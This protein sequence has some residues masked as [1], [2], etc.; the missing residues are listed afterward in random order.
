MK[1]SQLLTDVREM[2]NIR[3]STFK[4]WLKAAKPIADVEV[5]DIDRMTV[6]RYW[7]SQLKPIGTLS[8]E[9][10]RRR[11]S[12]LTGI[13]NMATEDEIIDAPN[14][15][16]K[17]SRKIK[18][19]TDYS[20][21]GKEY[22]V[23]PFSA[24]GRYQTD[25]IFLAIWF[26]GFRIG[27]IAGLMPNEIRF[28]NQVPYFRIRKNNNRD[29][30]PGAQR[31]VPIHPEFYAHINRLTTDCSQ[32]PGKNWSQVFSER[33]QLPK[34]EAAHSLRHNFITRCRS[35][36]LQDSMISKLVGHKINGMTARY[37]SWTLED[38]LK[39]IRQVRQ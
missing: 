23:R 19:N 28:D 30:K 36:E 16:S 9:T 2:Q 12:L 10:L 14:Y 15:W 4:C 34:G 24:Y 6:N 27:E 3:D 31:D 32:Y 22:P 38:K 39:A 20:R 25:P 29:I 18:L 7:K 8:P 35:A 13:W 33:M 21:L 1:V 26:H 11:L 37:G 17:A 5:S